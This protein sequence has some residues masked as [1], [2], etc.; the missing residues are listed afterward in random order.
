MEFFNNIKK[1]KYEGLKT[2]NM[3]AFHHYNPEEVV[4]GK[5]IK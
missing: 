5:P 4:L 3:F 1:I 2:E